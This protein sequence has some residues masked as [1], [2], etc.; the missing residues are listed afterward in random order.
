LDL[1]TGSI[2]EASLVQLPIPIADKADY[3]IDNTFEQANLTEV[4]TTS[5]IKERISFP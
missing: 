3:E 4:Y 2:Y 5:K 1:N